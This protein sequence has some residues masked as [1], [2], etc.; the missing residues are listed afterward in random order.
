[1]KKYA[2]LLL[3]ILTFFASA[4]PLHA[5]EKYSKDDINWMAKAMY[6]EARGEGEIG[7]LAVGLVILFRLESD[8]FSNRS[9]KDVVLQKGQFEKIKSVKIK[10]TF[11]LAHAK[12]L[13]NMLLKGDLPDDSRLEKI[14]EKRYLYFHVKRLKRHNDC[15]VVNHHIFYGG[16]S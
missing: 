16:D 1:M 5:E 7:M 15:V 9:I 3:F 11:E 4:L 8:K 6:H 2:K 14:I 13:A 12:D 10:D